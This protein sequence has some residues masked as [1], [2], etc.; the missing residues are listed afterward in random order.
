MAV[1]RPDPAE[2]EA[3]AVAEMAK[4]FEALEDS[5]EEESVE[6]ESVEEELAIEEGAEELGVK[7]SV[8]EEDTAVEEESV[9]KEEAV[10]ASSSPVEVRLFLPFVALSAVV[11][12]LVA[13]D[14]PERSGT[15]ST[16]F[17]FTIIHIFLP[18]YNR[19]YTSF[20]LPTRP[21]A[22][23][24]FQSHIISLHLFSLFPV[25]SP[26]YSTCHPRHFNGRMVAMDRPRLS[27]CTLC[28][29]L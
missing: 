18:F 8:E 29:G 28:L 12:W 11:D 19:P 24:L 9:E 7:E 1:I 17:L 5:V 2:F 3:K 27:C 20:S 23:S 21:S 10:E 4:E 16:F 25:Y 6:E 26:I 22:F 15:R 13:M 14:R